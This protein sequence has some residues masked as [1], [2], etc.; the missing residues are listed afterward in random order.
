MVIEP[1]LFHQEH[2]VGTVMHIMGDDVADGAAKGFELRRH[3]QGVQKEI[4]KAIFA[5]DFVCE[6]REL[7]A[8][9]IQPLK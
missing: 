9:N 8:G 3:I 5:R 4:V 6:L 1:D 7:S 2:D